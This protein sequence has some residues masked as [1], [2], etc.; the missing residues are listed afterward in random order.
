MANLIQMALL[1]G[2]FSKFSITEYKM[3][4]TP[5]KTEKIYKTTIFDNIDFV[6]F[7]NLKKIMRSD[8]KL[9]PTHTINI[10]NYYT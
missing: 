6:V 7:F 9:S 10:I 4:K 5:K 8:L 2:Y 1:E 3:V